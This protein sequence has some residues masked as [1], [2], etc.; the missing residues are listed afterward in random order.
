MGIRDWFKKNKNEEVENVGQQTMQEKQYPKMALGYN[1]GV[2]ADIKFKDV[3]DYQLE[4]GKSAHLQEVEVLYDVPNSNFEMKRYYI[5][6]IAM[7]DESGNWYYDSVGYYEK[8]KRENLS[9]LKAFFNRE[10]IYNLPSNYIGKLEIY[11]DGRKPARTFNQINGFYADYIQEHKRKLMEK[12]QAKADRFA[13][14]NARLVNKPHEVHYKTSHA[15]SLTPE[16]YQEMYGN[17]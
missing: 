15:E 4:N 13:Q 16:M 3:I 2:T 8:M 11:E 14:E 5:D 17:R 12:E 7:Q 6:P 9:L 10:S 1:N